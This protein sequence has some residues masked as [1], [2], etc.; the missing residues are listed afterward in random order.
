M[1][2]ALV[3]WN[4]RLLFADPPPLAMNSNLY[5]SPADGLDLDLG[6]QV[7]ARVLLGVGVERRELRV[8]QVVVGEGAE[9]A[10]RDGFAV[11]SHR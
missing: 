1:S 11:A 2:S 3:S 9:D 7:G 8:A 5:V 6:R 4:S 10:A